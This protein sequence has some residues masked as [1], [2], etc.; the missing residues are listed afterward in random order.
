MEIRQISTFAA[1]ARLGSFVQA[2]QSLGYAQSTIS[3]QIQLLESELGVRLFERLGHRI[4]LTDYGARLL[5]AAERLLS[6]ADEIRDLARDPNTPRGG[7][8]VGTGESLSA[9]RLPPLFRNYRQEFPQVEMTVRFANCRTLREQIRMG[10]VDVGVF[11]EHPIHDSD[12]LVKSLCK[13]DVLFL[14]VPGH[15]L[16]RKSETGPADFAGECL[17]IVV[18]KRLNIH[19]RL[20]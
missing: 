12:L 11:L 14:A 9:Y 6:A 16:L 1:A 7:L 2:A 4:N 13:V 3:T 15:K 18:D 5:P 19:M 17:L 20:I 8:V 10:D